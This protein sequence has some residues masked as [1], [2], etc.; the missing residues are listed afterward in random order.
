MLSWVRRRA[1]LMGWGRGACTAYCRRR[2][3]CSQSSAAEG[4][5]RRG[6]FGGG[7]G[8]GLDVEADLKGGYWRMAEWGSVERR[9]WNRRDRR[10]GV[11]VVVVVVVVDVIVIVIED[12]DG[13]VRM[14]RRGKKRD[15][16]IEAH[17]YQQRPLFLLFSTIR[18]L[19]DRFGRCEGGGRW[20]GVLCTANAAR[21]SL[22]LITTDGWLPE[23]PSGSARLCSAPGW[24]G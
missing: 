4:G 18:S 11:V 9:R 16:G 20:G 6:D 10:R 1:R 12:E 14:G 8:S 7:V 3:S 17:M 21:W 5:E 22:G 13:V 23:A 15:R 2:K 24:G 19:D